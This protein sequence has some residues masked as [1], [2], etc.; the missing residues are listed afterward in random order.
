[1]TDQHASAPVAIEKAGGQAGLLTEVGRGGL[2]HW[3]GYVYDDEDTRLQG[4]QAVRQ[5]RRM[6]KDPTVAA[7]LFALTTLLRSVNW[8]IEATDD[9]QEHKDARD[10]AEGVLFQDMEHT[11]NDFIADA[12]SMLPYGFAPFEMVYK[13]RSGTAKGMDPLKG[14]IFN[15]GRIGLKKIALRRQDTIQ[16]WWFDDDTDDLLGL[17][18]LDPMRG[19]EI[20]VPMDRLVLLRTTPNSGNPEGRSILEAAVRPYEQL[21]VFEHAEAS[22]AVRASGIVTLGIPAEVYSDPAK[23]ADWE[24]LAKQISEDRAGYIVLPTILNKDGKKVDAY[25][26]GYTVADGRRTGDFTP[27]IGRKKQEIAAVA[28]ADFILL[29]HNNKGA[30]SLSVDKTD[31]FKEAGT[32]I[33]GSIRDQVNRVVLPRIWAVNGLP[34]DTMPALQHE[35][36]DHE[37]LQVLSAFLTAMTS[38]GMQM[39]DTLE[40]ALRTKANLPLK[41]RTAETEPT[42]QPPP[43]PP[44]KTPPAK[45]GQDAG[46][47]EGDGLADASPEEAQQDGGDKPPAKRSTKPGQVAK[48]APEDIEELARVLPD[49]PA[50]REALAVLAGGPIP[51]GIDADEGGAPAA[52]HSPFHQALT[53][54]NPYH[55]ARG[56]FAAAPDRGGEGSADPAVSPSRMRHL[57]KTAASTHGSVGTHVLGTVANAKRIKR[58]TGIDLD[59]YQRVIEGSEIRHALK[60]HGNAKKEAAAGQIA[61]TP[62]DFRHIIAVTNHPDEIVTVGDTPRGNAVIRYSKAVGREMVF[63]SEEIRPGRKHAAFL[64]MWKRPATQRGTP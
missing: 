7:M 9:T 32:A 26:V 17:Y 4:L 25:T 33:L 50:Y 2:R 13:K 3:G 64:T 31:L 19:R 37:N 24:S 10:F 12:A 8:R 52:G 42:V 22:I 51:G 44:G 35:D 30:L 27:I 15:D 40:D 41:P 61:I 28:L 18:Q 20:Q 39:D 56:R 14:S 45:P 34:R 5:Y 43:G 36:L 46:D 53:K 29:G 23:L 16:R 21:R 47:D 38:A 49:D 62:D 60:R 55:D 11:W 1:M 59:G 58:E 63:V 6:T 54:H 57:A 48:A